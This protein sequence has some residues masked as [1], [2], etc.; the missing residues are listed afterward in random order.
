MSITHSLSPSTVPQKDVTVL[1]R[2]VVVNASLGLVGL[3]IASVLILP[4]AVALAAGSLEV[5]GTGAVANLA[6][7]FGS[8]MFLRKAQRARAIIKPSP[9][10]EL[11]LPASPGSL[12]E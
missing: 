8:L 9:S 12:G 6:L 3:S 1:R 5:L 11:K 10:G 4:K 2:R 7:V